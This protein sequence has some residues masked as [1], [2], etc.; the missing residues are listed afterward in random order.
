MFPDRGILRGA[1]CIKIC[2]RATQKMRSRLEINLPPDV[3][4]RVCKAAAAAGTSTSEY[5][6]GL[7]NRSVPKNVLISI[8]EKKAR[9]ADTIIPQGVVRR[10]V[11]ERRRVP[12]TPYRELARK[13]GYALRTVYRA[14]NGVRAYKTKF[15]HC[16]R[17]RKPRLT[18]EQLAAILID[19][20]CMTISELARKYKVSRPLIMRAI[21][22]EGCYARKS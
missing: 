7:I 1:G 12:P 6:L 20:Q 2:R 13:Y 8:Y 5:L 17:G 18:S 22:G 21:A 3:K 16:N 14:C 4:E 11:E 10:M 9:E 15:K 19:S